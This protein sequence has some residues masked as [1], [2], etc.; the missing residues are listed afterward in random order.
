MKLNDWPTS[1]RATRVSVVDLLPDDVREQL[2]ESRLAGNHS[3][4]AMVAWLKS[5]GHDQ[6]STSALSAWF[7]NRNLRHGGA[8]ADA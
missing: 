3:V 1:N 7:L 4:P 2:I 8:R 6:V 5:E